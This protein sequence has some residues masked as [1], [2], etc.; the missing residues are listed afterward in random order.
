MSVLLNLVFEV[1]VAF[2]PPPLVQPIAR[3]RIQTIA[4]STSQATLSHPTSQRATS[5]QTTSQKLA[6]EQEGGSEFPLETTPT[7]LLHKPSGDYS[8][9][10]E[11]FAYRNPRPDWNA[12][13]E[14]M[15]RE[16]FARIAKM[17]AEDALAAGEQPKSNSK[18]S[19]V[20]KAG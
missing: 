13:N 14:R 4:M 1:A 9:Q 7:S 11:A 15:R 12:I 5:S 3:I 16:E 19:K 20:N 2:K 8:K 17:K 6:T 18:N 10:F